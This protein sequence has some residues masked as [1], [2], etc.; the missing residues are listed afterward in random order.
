MTAPFHAGQAVR[1]IHDGKLGITTDSRA[2]RT[3]RI[4]VIWLGAPY[5]TYAQLD[6]IEHVEIQAV[7][8]REQIID[9]DPETL[10]E[11]RVEQSIAEHDRQMDAEHA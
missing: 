9:L 11:I 4:A 8:E 5:T 10:E 1:R 6:E 3:P 7:P 2:V